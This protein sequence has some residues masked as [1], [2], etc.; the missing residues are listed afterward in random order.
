MVFNQS[1]LK[2]QPRKL[3]KNI[4]FVLVFTVLC[5][6]RP[7]CFDTPVGLDFY[8]NFNFG[9]K[10]QP[11]SI[12]KTIQNRIDFLIEF[13]TDFFRILAPFWPP[14]GSHLGSTI[15]QNGAPVKDTGGLWQQLRTRSA[16]GYPQTLKMVA[17][18]GP[19]IPKLV[20]NGAPS[21]PKDT[22]VDIKTREKK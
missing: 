20:P 16:Q 11:K 10:H 17:Q 2:N 12:K 8:S 19:R 1:V 3:K 6:P 4:E 18:G 7:F 21:T 14:F 9:T 15:V 13:W 22:N 5:S